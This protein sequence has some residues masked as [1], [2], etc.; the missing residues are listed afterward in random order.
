M[1]TL[2]NVDTHLQYKIV[3]DVLFII[4]GDREFK[5]ISPKMI[6][7]LKKEVPSIESDWLKEEDL[8]I[9]EDFMNLVKK[10]NQHIA[11]NNV[12]NEAKELKI[13]NTHNEISCPIIEKNSVLSLS[14]ANI[15]IMDIHKTE[16]MNKL[17]EVAE[18]T[19]FIVIISKEIIVTKN[20]EFVHSQ[21]H[22]NVISYDKPTDLDVSLALNKA[23]ELLYEKEKFESLFYI[24]SKS[25][26][27]ISEQYY[28]DDWT[29]SKKLLNQ[30]F[31]IPNNNEEE[32]YEVISG[33]LKR[34]SR[35]AQVNQY[36]D[37]NQV[38]YNISLATFKSR[39][40][41]EEYY[42]VSDSPIKSYIE[43]FN[44]GLANFLN[45]I[46]EEKST[47]A[48]WIWASSSSD[49]E[50]TKYRL[51]I[52]HSLKWNKNLLRY[53]EVDLDTAI[54]LNEDMY[55]KRTLIKS[56]IKRECSSFF[57]RFLHLKGTSYYAL[58]VLNQNN[59]EVWN[60]VGKSLSVLF[61]LGL[62]F[63]YATA[64][65]N[66]AKLNETSDSFP[67]NDLEEYTMEDLLPLKEQ[68]DIDFDEKYP[69]TIYEWNYNHLLNRRTTILKIVLETF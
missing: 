48:E 41:I 46:D 60:S 16:Y 35:V 26:L 68:I 36:N 34:N 55:F 1:S 2:L 6:T 53:C 20:K 38:P 12:M 28:I 51:L 21:F 18:E 4:K 61:K 56:A 62:T 39:D 50:K 58:S 8:I 23:I 66:K 15:F 63:L 44:G 45:K 49:I 40:H 9:N 22:T 13:F 64:V 54:H 10:I 67:N 5:I 52:R 31:V 24:D 14:E 19:V 33:F 11:K 3:N 59:M 32:N 47:F 27:A 30:D 37:L 65:Q 17:D 25:R 43:A 42:S 7:I 69:F 29:K 57:F